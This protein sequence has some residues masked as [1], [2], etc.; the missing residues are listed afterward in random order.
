MTAV[1]LLLG[2][3]SA[4]GQALLRQ[5]S[6]P[7]P[8]HAISRQAMPSELADLSAVDLQWMMHDLMV[9]PVRL[10]WRILI[11]L[12]PVDHALR[13]VEA[14]GPNA[15][16]QQVIALSSAS[17]LFKLDSA[18]PAERAAMRALVEAERRL[19]RACLAR[20]VRLTLLKTAML[21]GGQ[22]NANIDRVAVLMARLPC[23]PVVGQGMRHPVHVEDLAALVA[24]LIG[25]E[26]VAGTWLL[27]GGEALSYSQ[28]LARIAD[29]RGLTL[30]PLRVP[31]AALRP[32]LA[33]AHVLGQL[34]DIRAVMLARQA[35]DLLVD[36]QPARRQL[37]WQPGPFRP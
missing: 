36:D 17:P 26:A 16:A 14:L 35:E 2:A 8:I 33:A 30:R 19:E 23:F 29:A 25:L 31:L 4:T 20:G 5:A 24:R 13:Q 27:G 7:G 9:A 11:S 10:D 18:D 34:K 15:S 37:A 22:P 28:M 3:S 1:T 32:L 6:A 12:G 21:Y